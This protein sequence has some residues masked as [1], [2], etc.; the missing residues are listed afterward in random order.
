MKSLNIVKVTCGGY[1]SAALTYTGDLYA[2]GRN[3]EG[4]CFQKI[5]QEDCVLTPSRLLI[6]EKV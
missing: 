5:D 1:H 3:K 2:W 6:H 4:Q